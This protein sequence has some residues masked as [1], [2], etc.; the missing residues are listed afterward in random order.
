MFFRRSSICSFHSFGEV[1]I[2]KEE[3]LNAEE[4]IKSGNN[5]EKKNLIWMKDVHFVIAVRGPVY[6]EDSSIDKQRTNIALKNQKYSPGDKI[7][8]CSLAYPAVIKQA[9]AVVQGNPGVELVLFDIPFPIKGDDDIINAYSKALE[10]HPGIKIT[11]IDHISS[12]TAI[13]FPVKAMVDL[14]HKHDVLAVIDGA[15]TPGQIKL[16]LED[17]G[18]DYYVGNLCKWMMIPQNAAFLWVHPKH[19]DETKPLVTSHTVYAAHFRD[20]FYP[21][22]TKDHICHI[23]VKD[24]IEFYEELGGLEAISARNAKMVTEAAA[25]LSEAWGTP[26]LEVTRDVRAPHMAVIGLPKDLTE[27]YVN[28]TPVD[29][30]HDLMKAGV[31]VRVSSIGEET[32]CR[33]SC[34]V[35]NDWD[36]FERVRDGVAML[37]KN[38]KMNTGEKIR[39]PYFVPHSIMDQTK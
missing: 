37:A 20:R 17:Y 35:W 12:D 5:Y 21:P 25:M 32:W 7:L 29:L 36:D 9:E 34:H 18:A 19:Q 22:M 15:H 11:V 27:A 33:I 6:R 23:L 8:L 14:C 38:S 28:N 16:T 30:Y 31:S 13:L 10:E 4:L 3:N 26:H 24:A 1:H 2:E 39:P